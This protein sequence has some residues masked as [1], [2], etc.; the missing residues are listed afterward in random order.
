MRFPTAPSATATRRS[1][2]TVSWTNTFPKTNFLRANTRSLIWPSFRGW[3]AT[4]GIASTSRSFR[5]SSGG[6]KCWARALPWPREWP[7]RLL[8]SVL[9]KEVVDLLDAQLRLAGYGLRADDAVHP[10]H[11]FLHACHHRA[12]FA[13]R[14]ASRVGK[15]VA[16]VAGEP[17]RLARGL[18]DLRITLRVQCFLAMP[19]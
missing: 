13:R 5:R 10:L 12:P 2:F 4:N 3:R 16:L 11:V 8:P 7:F 19:A 15:H 18:V 14:V 9:C 1:A 6:T 17:E